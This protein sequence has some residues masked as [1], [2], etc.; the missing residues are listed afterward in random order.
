MKFACIILAVVL[1]GCRTAS[2]NYSGGD[3]LSQEH[4]VIIKGAKDE[5]AGVEAERVWMEQRYPGFIKG[6]QSLLTSSGRQF[7][8]I[9]ITTHEG[10]KTIY[11]DIT[12]FFGK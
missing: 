11:F 1:V 5:I 8:E 7:D 3:G 12:D 6:Q 2:L 9:E 4:A 10:H